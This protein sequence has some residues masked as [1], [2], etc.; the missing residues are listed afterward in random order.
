MDFNHTEDRTML[1]DMVARFLADNYPLEERNKAAESADDFSRDQWAQF[2]ELGLIGALF[3]ESEGGFG[4]GFDIGVL[5]EEL[6]R[7]LVVEPFLASAVLAGGVLAELGNDNKNK[8]LVRLPPERHC[9]RSPMANRTAATICLALRPVQSGGKMAGRLT[10]QGC[11]SQRRQYRHSGR[12][13]TFS[14][15]GIRRRRN[16][17]LC[18]PCR[19]RGCLRPRLSDD[20]W[21]AR[22]R[23]H[24]GEC[25]AGRQRAAWRSRR[26]GLPRHRAC[27]RQSQ[28]RARVGG[29]EPHGSVPR[30]DLGIS[31]DAQAVRR[32]DRQTPGAA[33]SHGYRADGD[34]TGALRHHQCG[35]TP[36]FAAH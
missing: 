7:G 23:N 26:G 5:F 14:R 32:S 28:C 6:G 29:R 19:A 10:G 13:G 36:R 9:S 18:R 2:A 21:I 16:L 27:D 25:D 31:A 17:R 24:S 3:S 35:R 30:H 20:R 12:H 11:G 22:R 34:R 4:G 33:A 15:R 8:C 1:K